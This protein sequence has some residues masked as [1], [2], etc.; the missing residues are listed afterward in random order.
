MYVRHYNVS[1]KENMDG[2]LKIWYILYFKIYYSLD[3]EVTI[4]PKST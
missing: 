3:D 1:N 2:A 4:S